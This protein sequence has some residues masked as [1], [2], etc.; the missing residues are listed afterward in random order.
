MGYA[1]VNTTTEQST[2]SLV[3]GLKE[4]RTD[5]GFNIV[6]QM[7]WNMTYESVK[8]PNSGEV[9]FKAG[10]E[11]RGLYFVK[12]GAVKILVR[13]S[14]QRGRMSNEE[15]I[16][17][18]V[19]PGE[20]FG[21]QNLLG[22]SVNSTS[23]ET[24]RDTE[25]HFYSKENIMAAME[26]LPVFVK[27]ILTQAMKDIAHLEAQA[28]L[29]YL[30]SVQER[31]AFQIYNLS[32]RFGEPDPRAVSDATERGSFISLKLSRNELA[33]LAGTINESLSRHL[34]DLKNEGIIEL[35][36]RDILVK[37][38]AALLERAGSMSQAHA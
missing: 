9:I 21:Y 15:F 13:K 23:A 28:Q 4:T 14:V 10:D 7:P 1:A 37:N 2:P 32:E 22:G 11:P 38:K 17:K 24:A 18:I 33:Q 26:T 8:L 27:G 34:T 30:A 6:N 29:H 36:G 12:S 19:G 35:R 3:G 16:T 31:I 25:L 5:K 20:Y